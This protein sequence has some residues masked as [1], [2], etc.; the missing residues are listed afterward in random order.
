MQMTGEFE[1]FVKLL[2]SKKVEYVIVGA[3]ALAFH[4]APRFTGDLDVFIAKSEENAKRVLDAI[5]GFGLGSLDL[6]EKDFLEEDHVVQLGVTPI[7]IDL[8][9]GL[10][11]VEWEEVRANSVVGTYGSE[12][13]RYIGKA[14]YIK[15]KK[16]LGRHKD[17]ADIESI[18]S[19][20]KE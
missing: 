18:H 13:V 6:N 20:D 2:N 12:I 9:T 19:V 3:F 8:L 15:N 11:G 16:A 7:R 14:E 1:E 10:T 4:G 5:E 17:F